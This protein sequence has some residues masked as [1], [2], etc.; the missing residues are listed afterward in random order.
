MAE[1]LDRTWWSAY[2]ARLER[3]FRQ[4]VVVIRASAVEVI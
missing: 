4:D 1:D 2:R 3:D